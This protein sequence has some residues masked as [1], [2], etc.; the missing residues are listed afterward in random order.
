MGLIDFSIANAGEIGK[1]DS[2]WFSD[3]FHAAVKD[4]FT[5]GILISAGGDRAVFFD[6][7]RPV[8]ASGQ[9]FAGHYLGEILIADKHVESSLVAETVKR[10]Q[11]SNPK[12]LLGALLIEGARLDPAVIKKAMQAQTQRRVL[13][14]FALSEGTWKSAPGKDARIFQIGVPIDARPL[15]LQGLIHASDREQR[16]TSDLLLGKAVSLAHDAARL[17]G[18]ALDETAKKV[19]KYLDKPRK[20]DQL[21]RAVGNRKLVRA[22]LRL[23]AIEDALQLD[24]VGKAIPIPKATLVKPDV[25][26]SSTSSP[27]ITQDIKPVEPPPAA[28]KM[29]IPRMP[30]RLNPIAKEMKESF[31]SLK[32]KNFFELFGVSQTVPVD[33]AVLRKTY[34]TLAKKYHPDSIGNDA[35]E[36]LKTMTRELSALVNDAY[37]TLSDEKRRAEYLFLLADDRIKGDSRKAELIRDAE[38]KFKMGTVMLKKKDYQKAREFFKYA[39]E[40]DPTTAMYKSSLA[41]AMFSDPEFDKEKALDKGYALIL[42]ALGSKTVDAQTHFVAAQIAK[43]RGD[44]KE[45][46]HQFRQA[47]KLD[48][49]HADAQRELR[50]IDMRS[51]KKRGDSKSKGG[52]LSKLFKRD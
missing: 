25:P 2:L 38:T 33:A 40:G 35:P 50:L 32:K 10:Q 44:M 51:D 8:H 30:S 16:V 31:E 39:A 13:E 37:E 7:G 24:P 6:G 4:E 47:V 41:W 34:T 27:P 17:Q 45:A 46:E 5:G 1:N 19:L 28:P 14:L 18:F 3:L 26:I 23:L 21:E 22:L 36:D 11:G 52:A 29:A 42:E 43:A 9:G 20:P 12:P 49:N 15:L 48:K